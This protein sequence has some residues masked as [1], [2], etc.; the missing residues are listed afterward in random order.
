MH[1]SKQS[2]DSTLKEGDFCE[3]IEGTHAGK[4]GTVRDVKISKSG[5]MTIT[6]VQS[7]GERIK[8]LA[9]NVLIKQR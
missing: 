2:T 9:K 7:N 8:T 6:V 4:T 3:V 5:N 1:D